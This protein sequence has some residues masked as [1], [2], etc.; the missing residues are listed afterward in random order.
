MCVLDI[1]FKA[2]FFIK[3]P[4]ERRIILPIIFY[5]TDFTI[6]C[7]KKCHKNVVKDHSRQGLIL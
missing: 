4:E 1:L 2:K 7:R 3:E 6:F 5:M